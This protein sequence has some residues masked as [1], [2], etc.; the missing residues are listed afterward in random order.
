MTGAAVVAPFS[1]ETDATERRRLAYERWLV[2]SRQVRFA[3][4]A[5]P[6]I[7]GVILV[8]IIGALEA[9]GLMRHLGDVGASTGL[10]IHMTNAQFFGR[11]KSGRP[12]V[13]SASEAARDDRDLARFVLTMPQLVLD[14]GNPKA[15]RVSAASGVYRQD[16]RIAEL[17]GKV[18]VTDGQ[19]DT[20][21]TDRAIVDTAHGAVTGPS[22]VRGAG[23]MGVITAQSFEVLQNGQRVVLRGNVH[24]IIKKD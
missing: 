10:S 5:L 24:S 3:R 16:N 20:F 18:T 17:N 6:V 21:V 9:R 1:T 8:L 15:S 12:F 2:R 23:P 7:I 13:V 4:R 14:A 19:G 11:D 22:P